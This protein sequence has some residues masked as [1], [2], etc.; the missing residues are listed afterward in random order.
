MKISE[1]ILGGN[2]P[3][4]IRPKARPTQ[5]GLQD[6]PDDKKQPLPGAPKK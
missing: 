1:I 5:S 4:P 2:K 6:K 3:R